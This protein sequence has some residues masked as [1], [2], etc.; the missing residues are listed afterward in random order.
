MRLYECGVRLERIQ[1]NGQS[2]KVTELYLVD[3]LT[4]TEA[5]A[6]IIEKIK[7]E[8]SGDVE[9]ISLKITNYSEVITSNSDADE[10]DSTGDETAEKADRWFR[11]KVN[12][13]PESANG[14][15][16][17]VPSYYILNAGDM[18]DA[19]KVLA[20][21][22]RGTVTDYDVATLDETRIIDVYLHN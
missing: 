10:R 22:L 18:D 15:P 17:K 13:Y 2:K 3:A 6:R 21:F 5:E 8:V 7:A 19:H 4:F 14:S 9:V 1:A 20:D 16:K 11:V 12:Y